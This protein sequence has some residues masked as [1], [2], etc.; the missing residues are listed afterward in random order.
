MV[1]GEEVS[2]PPGPATWAPPGGLTPL[3]AAMFTA[4]AT[5]EMLEPAADAADEAAVT[6]RAEVLAHLLTDGTCE[7]A[8]KGVRLRWVRIAGQLDLAGATVRCPLVLDRCYLDGE[9]PVSLDF[10]EVTV[11]GLIGCKL[12]GLFG[13]TLKVSK[14]LNLA[15]STLTGPLML[16]CADVAGD[17]D[18]TGARLA[19]NG[20]ALSAATIK[21]GGNA[22]L[23][24][25]VTTNGGID[26]ECADIKGA[27]VCSG[28]QLGG[29]ITREG[30]SHSLFGQWVKV[31]GPARLNLRRKG[32]T[33]TA[34]YCVYLLGASISGNLNCRNA[35]LK[36]PG[37]ALMG[38]RINVG[39]NVLLERVVARTGEIL[40][41]SAEISGN[42]K[43]TD[44][45]LTGGQFAIRG[46]RL[47][48]HGDML[49]GAEKLDPMPIG[50]ILLVDATIDGNVPLSKAKLHGAAFALY[51]E[52]LKVVGDL[53]F[54]ATSS[55][56]GAIW[57]RGASVGGKLTWAP[58]E[59]MTGYVNLADAKA[60]QLEDDWTRPN[61]FWP[62]GGRLNIVGFRYGTLSG[63]QQGDA[64]QRLDWIRCQ[65]SSD[66]NEPAGAD[67][68]DESQEAGKAAAPKGTLGLLPAA[69][70][71]RASFATQPYEQLANVYQQAGQDSDARAIAI[72]RRRDPRHFAGLTWYRKTLSWLL[73]RTIQY[74][75]QTW[76]AVLGLGLV[77]VVAVV[78]FTLAQHHGNLIVPLAQTSSGKPA[79]S[80]G[81]C[82]ARYPC[83]YPAGYAIDT[84][85]PIINVHQATYWGPNGDSAAG[86]ALTVFTWL[87]T[88]LGWA[89]A[90]LS[91]AGYTG[92][93]RNTDS[94]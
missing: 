38:E 66:G 23:A 27:L 79:P 40:L 63:T 3:E 37:T 31:G 77:Y 86:T 39:G 32:V 91:V 49:L 20:E 74:G 4:A 55:P 76:R 15:A 6:I 18:C 47:K 65:W 67:E 12:P 44:S 42:L 83:F 93:V 84:V 22:I 13:K 8:A 19:G 50:R 68:T 5:G 69:A 56:N 33:F 82:T 58:A 9:L 52:R 17:L 28:A 10:A 1:S 36:G 7:I 46:D 53:S 71:G 57:L 88:A 11:V 60:D 54:E 30:K 43:C 2:A 45:Q 24:E 72:G 85:I 75:Y 89:L 78:V 21:V 62:A 26:L 59:P 51:G 90:T 81:Q 14:D 80:V 87:C 16:R 73:D 94:L 61:A 29:A 35:V 92:L 25:V 41:S 34:A 64:G 48:V 70:S